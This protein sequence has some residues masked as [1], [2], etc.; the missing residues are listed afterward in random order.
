VGLRRLFPPAAVVGL[1]AAVVAGCG[2][3]G[4]GGVIPTF[5]P[6][7]WFGG[8]DSLTSDTCWGRLYNLGSLGSHTARNVRI[9]LWY[10]TGLREDPH[11]VASNPV[12]ILDVGRFACPPQLTNG[13][14]RYP[15]LGRISWDGGSMDQSLLGGVRNP[16]IS[17]ETV[18][19]RAGPDSVR[20]R[21]GNGDGGWA[22]RVVVR[23]ETNRGVLD[24][25][26]T[27]DHLGFRQFSSY[28]CPVLDSASATP[29][30]LIRVQWEDY[31]GIPGHVDL[32]P[33][34]NQIYDCSY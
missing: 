5:P 13:D 7:V 8:W 11:V 26:T 32:T 15:R 2:G 12:D 30:R 34:L 14:P 10:A 31:G 24:I 16:L 29:P 27:P 3:G 18:W 20:G 25:P 19:C 1:L 4:G 21:V 33:T 28:Y 23:V 22:Y 17:G 6:E 9:Q